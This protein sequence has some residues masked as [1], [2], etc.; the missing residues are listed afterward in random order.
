MWLTPCARSTSSARSASPL[1]TLPSAAA[2]KMTRLDSW[3]V[4]PNGACW[5]TSASVRPPGGGRW[6]AAAEDP[7]LQPVVPEG[8]AGGHPLGQAHEVR[9]PL[10]ERCDRRRLGHEDL[11]PVRPGPEGLQGGL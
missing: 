5:I 4:A 6:S 7:G 2:P 11:A 9:V 1:E 10:V 3:P 8:T